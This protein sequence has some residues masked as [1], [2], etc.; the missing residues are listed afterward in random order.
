MHAEE[1]QKNFFIKAGRPN[2]ERP[3]EKNISLR[4]NLWSLR[5]ASGL[6]IL[7]LSVVHAREAAAPYRRCQNP[8]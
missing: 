7:I 4:D 6:L 1:V 8:R 3:A 2:D 5:S